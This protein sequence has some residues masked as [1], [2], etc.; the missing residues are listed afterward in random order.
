MNETAR[1]FNIASGDRRHGAAVIETR[2][3]EGLL[4]ARRVWTVDELVRGAAM[5]RAGQPAMANLRSLA[6][7]IVEDEPAVLETYMT[8]RLVVLGELDHRFAEEAWPHVEGC[9]R[10]LSLSRSS[11]VAAVLV[12]AWDRGWRG[13]TVIFDGTRAGRGCD[14]A[15]IL[16]E[17]IEGV[18]SLPDATM[19]GWLA[20]D[21]TL[22]VIGA[23]AVSP[24]RLVN[25]SGTAALL[26]LAAAR[27]V[28]TMVVADSGKDIADEE[29]DEILA[30]G[31]SA[32][33][34]DPGRSWP[35]FEA[36]ACRLATTRIHE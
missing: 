5:L 2:L 21:K 13:E 1:L 19:P 8:Q 33:D 36:V 15:R 34:E 6:R 24:R 14:Q 28:P 17:S 16:A 26:E 29:I 30:V 4:R 20:G 10:V 7:R 31:P 18:R 22:V 9:R 25:A 12:G 35:V 11:A 32:S 3:I 27:G 23:D